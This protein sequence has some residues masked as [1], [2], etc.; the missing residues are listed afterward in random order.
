MNIRPFVVEFTGTPEAGKTTSIR[1]V[2]PFITDKLHCKIA[3]IQESAEL[4]PSKFTKGSFEANVW[5]S[6]KTIVTLISSIQDTSN[7]IIIADRGTI[8]I[9]FFGYKFYQQHLCSEEE[10]RNYMNLYSYSRAPPDLCISLITTPE[11][12]IRRRGGE[13]RL[14]TLDWVRFYNTFF[15]EFMSRFQRNYTITAFFTLD[16]TGLTPSEVTELI[17]NTIIT[18]YQNFKKWET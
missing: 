3:V 15:E 9:H 17:S 8:D 7:D 14:V 11:E 2:I 12:A 4:L 10:Y 5:M 16:T 6:Q 13:G 1:K 18:S